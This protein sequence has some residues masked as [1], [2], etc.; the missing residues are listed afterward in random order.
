MGRPI[1]LLARKFALKSERLSTRVNACGS[2]ISS[3]AHPSTFPYF[4]YKILIYMMIL[5]LRTCSY[6]YLVRFVQTEHSLTPTSRALLFILLE[7]K[8]PTFAPLDRPSLPRE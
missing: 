7:E 6:P 4:S 2:K 3:A 8:R 5:Y 1:F